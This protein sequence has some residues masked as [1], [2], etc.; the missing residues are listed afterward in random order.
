LAAEDDR[1]RR[2]GDGTGEHNLGYRTRGLY[3]DQLTRY[4]ALFPRD[5]LL[6]LRSEDLFANPQPVVDRVCH[7]LGIDPALSSRTFRPEN[8]GGYN[9][10]EVPGSVYAELTRFFTPHNQRLYELV[11][12]DWDWKRSDK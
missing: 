1:L 11:G 7:F 5:Q 6:V 8:L 9:A 2:K 3:A 10:G 4:Y 12:E